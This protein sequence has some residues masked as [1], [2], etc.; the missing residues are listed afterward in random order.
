MM[1]RMINIVQL[2]NLL[3]MI[4]L[5]F[6]GAKVMKYLQCASI[7]LFMGRYCIL[8]INFDQLWN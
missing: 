1:Q 5:F 3:L 4:R 8:Q 6:G 2:M 7:I